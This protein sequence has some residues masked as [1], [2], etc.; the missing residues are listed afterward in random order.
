MNFF[1]QS[2]NGNFEN[3][4]IS[5][6]TKSDEK[7]DRVAERDTVEK[8]EDIRAFGDFLDKT[9]SD[10][11]SHDKDKKSK[12]K[13]KHKDKGNQENHSHKMSR[14]LKENV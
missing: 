2:D 6:R 7:T 8:D 13:K 3:I 10:E 9:R 14:N 1:F 11:D 12:K 4:K 5:V